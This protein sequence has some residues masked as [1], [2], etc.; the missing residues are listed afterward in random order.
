MKT[1]SISLQFKNINKFGGENS[2]HLLIS[3]FDSAYC[4]LYYPFRVLSPLWLSFLSYQKQ[5]IIYLR[6]FE[7]KLKCSKN[8]TFIHHFNHCQCWIVYLI[9]SKSK[10]IRHPIFFH[11]NNSIIDSAMNLSYGWMK[12]MNFIGSL[13]VD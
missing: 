4:C 10:N 2:F 8:E 9:L 7:I 6:K 3:L 5:L 1:D 12:I 11:I 13:E